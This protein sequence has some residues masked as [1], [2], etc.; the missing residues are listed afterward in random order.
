MSL[1]GFFISFSIALIAL[2]IT[3]G[4]LTRKQRKVKMKYEIWPRIYVVYAIILLALLSSSIYFCEA[5][6]EESVRI[7]LFTFLVLLGSFFFLSNF[8][9]REE[10]EKISKVDW[11]VAVSCQLLFI[12]FVL[13]DPIYLS[14]ND[15][16]RHTIVLYPLVFFLIVFL[17]SFLSSIFRDILLLSPSS[18]Q[19]G[20]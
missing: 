6:R 17:L 10:G 13:G 18:N 9:D 8:R 16:L 15:E 7:P 14:D 2:S 20:R 4:F 5:G 1:I 11:I 3:F 12:F 19:K